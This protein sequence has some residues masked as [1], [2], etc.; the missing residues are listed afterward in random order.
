[1][2]IFVFA[3]MKCQH[4]N[5]SKKS[6]ASHLRKACED[7]QEAVFA[8]CL[9][10]DRDINEVMQRGSILTSLCSASQ[11]GEYFLFFSNTDLIQINPDSNYFYLCNIP[12]IIGF[13][14]VKDSWI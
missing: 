1:M 6:S 8:V 13:A 2:T 9:R 11:N 4:M 7:R 14:K 5:V 12:K 10:I 3:T